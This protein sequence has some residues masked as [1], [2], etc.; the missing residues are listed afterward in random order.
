MGMKTKM[1]WPLKTKTCLIWRQHL[2]APWR[3]LTK[4]AR[5]KH[6][7]FTYTYHQRRTSFTFLSWPQSVSDKSHL[8]AA[9]AYNRHIS[10]RPREEFWRSGAIVQADRAKL[11]VVE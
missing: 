6:Y 7:S 3:R 2:I 1:M 9:V 10:A 11:L 8:G 5:K 4:Y